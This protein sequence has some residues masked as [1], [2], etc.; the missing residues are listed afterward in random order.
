MPRSRKITP[1]SAAFFARDVEAV[2][3]ELI[4]FG[5]YVDGVGGTIVEVEAYDRQD[6]ASHTYNG[7]TKRNAAMFGPSGHAYVY[8]I[9]GAHWCLNFVCGAEPTG[10][11]VLIRAIEPLTGLDVMSERRG[12]TQPRLLCSGPGRLCQALGVTN[13]MD[14]ASL[15]RT[16]FELHAATEPAPLVIGQRIGITKGVETPWRFGRA[17]SAYLSRPFR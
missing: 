3:R 5:L 10:S 9:Y 8:R 1:L 15:D 7:P 13:A 12:T 2:A 17:G 6:P 14:G 4:G 11:A 16:P